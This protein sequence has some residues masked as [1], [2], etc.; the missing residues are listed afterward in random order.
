MQYFLVKWKLIPDGAKPSS[1]QI[2]IQET[3]ITEVETAFSEYM[4]GSVAE[5]EI[6]SIAASKISEVIINTNENRT[7][8]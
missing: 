2:L 8:S 4:V 6:N 3:G 1:H 5:Y 7:A